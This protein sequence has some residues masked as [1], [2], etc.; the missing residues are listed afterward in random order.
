MPYIIG[1]YLQL[2][3]FLR[4]QQDTYQFYDRVWV[5]H[6]DKVNQCTVFSYQTIEVDECDHL[7]PFICE[8]DPEVTINL[9]FW[10]DDTAT[11]AVIGVV[12][13]IL[14]LMAVILG[15]WC[16]KSRKRHEERLERR[17]SIRQSLRSLK[18][19]GSTNG[20][21]DIGYRQNVNSQKSSPTLTKE[22]KKMMN[23]SL[24]SM[25]KSQYNSS[26]DDTQSYDIYEAHNPSL[27]ARW[28]R[29]HHSFDLTY[30]NK[31]FRDNSTFASRENNAYS[32]SNQTESYYDAGTLPM[33]SSVANTDSIAD[34]K[35]G[36]SPT[37]KFDASSYR[38]NDYYAHTPTLE[39]TESV[40][41]PDSEITE[42]G[43]FYKNPPP[44]QTYYDYNNSVLDMNKHNRP[45][46]ESLLETNIDD[47]KTH[48]HLLPKSKSEALLE[49]NFDVCEVGLPELNEA[50]SLTNRSKS[51]P[52]ETSM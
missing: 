23:G 12:S 44:M 2:Y 34:I 1:N 14:L 32:D 16:S 31:G 28:D 17:N 46:T 24:D 42:N 25:E 26:I 27:S 41:T 30:Q 40:M 5:Q 35:K 36:I 4:S 6:L 8:I 50:L 19:I 20:L 39:R 37:P 7:S 11:L 48:A 47:D 29:P 3:Q 9:L 10:K 21:S 43:Y 45:S 18:S 51:Q 38:T 13:A 49:T 15:F 33:G 52:L 22:Y